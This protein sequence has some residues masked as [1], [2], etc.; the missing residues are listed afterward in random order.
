MHYKLRLI[1]EPSCNT[2]TPLVPAGALT[3]DILT[4][5]VTL[6]ARLATSFQTSPADIDLIT[7]I[8]CSTHV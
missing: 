2:Q 7:L 6:Q 1:S 4:P 3:W 8:E 5:S